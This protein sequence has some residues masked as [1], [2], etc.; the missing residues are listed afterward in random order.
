MSEEQVNEGTESEEVQD[1]PYAD[2]VFG[3]TSR[4][5]NL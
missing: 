4:R 1:N 3:E 5:S 2:V